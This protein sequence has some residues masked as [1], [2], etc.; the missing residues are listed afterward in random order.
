MLFIAFS[1]IAY[2]YIVGFKSGSLL[3]HPIVATFLTYALLRTKS[4]KQLSHI[5]NL[6]L[7]LI[8]IWLFVKL[9]AVFMPFIIGFSLAYIV[10]SALEGLRTI[11]LT[12][13]RRLHLSRVHA[14]LIFVAIVLSLLT[15]I[16][17]GIVPQIIEQSIAMKDG[18][19]GLYSSLND[20]ASRISEDI[21]VGEYPF[22][23]YL[24]ESWQEPLGE[25]ISN[26]LLDVQQRIPSVAQSVSEVI[27]NIV[28][29][30]YVGIYGT[31]GKISTAFFVT[32]IFIYLVQAFKPTI[33]KITDLL[34]KE[35]SYILG[36][37]LKEIDKDMKAFLKGQLLVI[38]LVSIIYI[39]AYAIIRVPFA[40]L[41]GLLAGLCNAI[42]TIG[43]ILGGLI[44]FI[45]V[46]T[47]L[48][49]KSYGLNRFLIRTVLVIG[50]SIGVQT[51]DN[52]LISPKI[53]S[54]AI[55]VHPLVIL[56][57]VLLSASI[58]GIWGAVLAIPGVIIVKAVINVSKELSGS[59]KSTSD[60]VQQ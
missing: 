41:I 45:S 9:M 2:A 12:R 35:R 58:F 32:I 38:I 26:L 53:M 46:L 20:F 50:V 24:P 17:L 49:A 15:F 27:V 30:L 60:V 39:I 34:P 54:K 31:L 7:T 19:L 48:A 28:G 59:D 55:E 52:S 36:L 5:F 47:G 14:S 11:P 56:F 10:D 18:I 22:K 37:Y 57:A 44:A 21:S 6:G 25:A 43:P 40:L 8:G 29:H 33:K 23:Y 51:L 3:S 42:P 13:H 16:G 4:T 1:W